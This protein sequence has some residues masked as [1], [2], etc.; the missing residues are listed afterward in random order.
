MKILV[1]TSKR[2]QNQGLG[3]GD[4]MGPVEFG[5]DV[6]GEPAAG[7]RL[8]G[9]G[10]I[11]RGR[12]KIAAEGD[13]DLG[14]SCMHGLDGS[15]RVVTSFGGGLKMAD[16]FES[17]QK[18]RSGVFGDAHGAIPLH[19]AMP[20]DGAGASAWFSDVAAQQ[21]E[22]DN[23]LHVGDRV[24]MLG[25]AHGPGTDN[26]PGL[27]SDIRSLL[28]VFAWNPAAFLNFFPG[29]VPCDGGE[30]VE[31][32][33]VF[34]YE[35]QV[36]NG[37]RILFLPHEQFLHD[38]LEQGDVAVDFD[39]EKQRGDWRSLT[40]PAGDF[41][42]MNEPGGPGF[43]KW[44][45][46]DNLT[47]SPGGLLKSGEHTRMVGARILSQDEDGVGLVEIVERDSGFAD[48]DDFF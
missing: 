24:F 29:Y 30:V 4:Q 17:I 19:I 6:D 1:G 45:D 41:L 28:N 23:F 20:T 13:E 27:F 8:R 37:A 35:R 42:G 38:A 21:E 14:L 32:F 40:Q 12:E 26:T 44:I 34:L 31:S 15:H 46:A 47:S 25:H 43:G 22:V 18:F 7:K 16:L 5:G 11:R 33:G 39:W 3:S 48:A 10:C 2:G 9:I 36:E